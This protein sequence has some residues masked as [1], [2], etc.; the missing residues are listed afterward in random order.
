M[1]LMGQ[2][3]PAVQKDNSESREGIGDDLGFF[4]FPMVAGG[5]GNPGD[6]FGGGN[7]FAV[8]KNASPK[9]LISSSG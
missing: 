9:R 8:G 7:G 5:A 3:A 6:A 1:E 2:W 4:G